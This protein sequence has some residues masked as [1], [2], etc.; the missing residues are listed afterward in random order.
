MPKKRRGTRL[1]GMQAAERDTNKK[2]TIYSVLLTKETEE[3]MHYFTKLELQ[4]IAK[5]DR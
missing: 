2:K 3:E 4:T 5:L 1:N